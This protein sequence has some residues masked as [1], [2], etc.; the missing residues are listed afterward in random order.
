MNIVLGAKLFKPVC[1]AAAGGNNNIIGINLKVF[2]A[3]GNISAYAGIPFKFKVRA[4]IS[5]EN[6]NAVIKKIFFN[7][8]VKI[9][10]LFRTKVAELNY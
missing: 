7:S 5:K 4:F 3:V 6:F 9:L 8:S 2:P 1:A 10:R